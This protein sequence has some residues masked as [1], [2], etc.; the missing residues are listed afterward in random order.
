M[1]SKKRKNSEIKNAILKHIYNNIKV[2]ITLLIIFLIGLILGIIFINNMKQEGQTEISSYIT[3]FINSL[4]ENNLIDKGALLKKSIKFNL[5]TAFLLWFSGSTVT[6]LPIVYALIGYRGFCFGYSIS[7][8][9]AC[10]GTKNGII[11]CFSSMFF[12]TLLLIPSIFILAVSG[13]NLYESIIR[14]RRKEN[15][16]LEIYRHT[17]LTVIMSLI[18][19]VSSFIES[20]ISSNLLYFFIKYI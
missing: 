15:I 7:S 17:I 16:K 12:Q 20:Y 13:I 11:F 8:I 14:D 5:L 19:V 3:N 6:G 9:I 4:K 1:K 2:Y 18:L 10:L